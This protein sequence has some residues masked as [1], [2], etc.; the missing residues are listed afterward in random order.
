M[1]TN[2]MKL[3]LALG[4]LIASLGVHAQEKQFE[5]YADV[6]GVQYVY[7]SKAMLQLVGN[8]AAPKVPGINMKGIADKLTSMQVI[9]SEEKEQTAKLKSDALYITKNE[10]YEILMQIDEDGDKIR[11]YFKEGKSQSHLLMLMEEDDEIGVFIL[12]GTFKKKDLE[13]LSNMADNK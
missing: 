11:I 10:K 9:S 13:A 8:M 2:L 5:K 4:L 7:I 6:K 1:K 3:M 12:S